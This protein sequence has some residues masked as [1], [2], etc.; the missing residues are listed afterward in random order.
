MSDREQATGMPVDVRRHWII[1]EPKEPP[2]PDSVELIKQELRHLETVVIPD[3]NRRL[4]GARRR[5]QPVLT[6]EWDEA[7][8]RRTQLLRELD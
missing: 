8:E 2:L 4:E 6:K 1:P 7:Q 3:I 5:L